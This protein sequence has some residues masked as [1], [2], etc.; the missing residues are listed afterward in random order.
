MELINRS[1][2]PVAATRVLDK[3]GHEHLLV[4][5][6]A[7]YRFG[8]DGRPPRL[9]DNGR[10]IEHADVF[11]GEPGLSA[12]L[13]EA[14]MVLRKQ[15]CDV[16]LNASAHTADGRPV[17][18]LDVGVRV[19]AMTK[20]LLVVGDRVWQRGAIGVTPSRPEPF[21]SMPLRYDRAFGGS[22]PRQASRDGAVEYDT[23]LLN[24][25][26]VG[27]SSD[28]SADAVD[29]MPM[30]NT[31]DPRDRVTSPDHPYRPLA[32]GPIGRHWDPRRR[33]AGT[34]DARWREEVF[35]LLPDDFD[36]T[37]FQCAPA[38]QQIAFPQGGE[39]VVLRH[40][41]PRRALA[42]F[43]LPRPELAIKVLYASQAADELR[44][45]VDTLYVEP[46]E[47]FLTMVYRASLPLDRRGVFGVKIVALGPV[48]KRWWSAQVLGTADC[49]CGGDD[50]KDPSP[51]DA[52]EG[53]GDRTGA[54]DPD[55]D[56]DL[57]GGEG[58]EE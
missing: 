57:G 41:M 33:Y 1:G 36:E 35:P 23:Y 44:P 15:R 51:A 20:Q 9:A 28:A 48:C 2:L 12:P 47:G 31:E 3:G 39:A 5:A 14:D 22:R 37:F 34:Y 40:L 7:T 52:P 54:D 45:V 4:V 42:S 10:P 30:P 17:T 21:V 26:G 53:S 43:E 13:Y 58:I 50:S 27:Y 49:G 55:T 38:D 24:P 18:E 8:D 29:H 6:K 46:D 56:L 32:L 19:G 16:I 11:V 25:V